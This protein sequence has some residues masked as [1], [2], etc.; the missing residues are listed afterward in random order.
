[1]EGFPELEAFHTSG[2]TSTLPET[3]QGQVGECFEKTLRYPGHVRMLRSLYDLGL[4]SSVKRVVNGSEVA[5]RQMMSRL[6]EEKFTS[7]EPEVTLLR[8]EA[9]HENVVASFSMIDYTDPVTGTTSMMR[10]TA[11]PASI[12]LQMLIGGEISKRGGVRQ[13]IDIPAQLFLKEMALREVRDSLPHRVG[14]GAPRGSSGRGTGELIE[15]SKS[16][17][18]AWTAGSATGVG[19][20]HDRPRLSE[21]FWRDVASSWGCCRTWVSLPWMGYL[22]VA[23]EFGGGILLVV[24]FLTRLAALA[25]FIDMLVAISK[26]HLHNGLFSKNGGF[27]FPMVCGAIAFSLIWSG[28]GPSRSIGCGEVRADDSRTQREENRQHRCAGDL[29]RSSASNRRSLELRRPRSAACARDD[30]F[31]R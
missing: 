5:P 4:F 25:I 20:G 9:H 15:L 10:T 1:M 16:P 18:P 6:F 29:D 8:V 30:K 27:E 21:S 24:G 7:E 13:E 22:T 19:H 31:F 3:F 14:R 11:W 23:A 2:G 26:V 28:P 12:V 17:A